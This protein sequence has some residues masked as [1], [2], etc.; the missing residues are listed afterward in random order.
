M[1]RFS[2]EL[3]LIDYVTAQRVYHSIYEYVSYDSE[4]ERAFAMQL[5]ID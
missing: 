1:R 5:D 2:E 3:G 4:I